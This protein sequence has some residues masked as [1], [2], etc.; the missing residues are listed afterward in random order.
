MGARKLPAILGGDHAA[1]I[2]YAPLCQGIPRIEI[3]LGFHVHNQANQLPGVRS[4]G[5][6]TD[7]VSDR[8]LVNGFVLRIQAADDAS[9]LVRQHRNAGHLGLALDVLLLDIAHRAVPVLRQ[10]GFHDPGQNCFFGEDSLAGRIVARA[11][12]CAM[13]ALGHCGF[14]VHGSSPSLLHSIT[15]LR[16]RPLFFRTPGLENKQMYWAAT[17]PPP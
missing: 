1:A 12:I 3:V 9:F 17:E 2:V 10:T 13:Q 6:E 11:V 15:G 16:S 5:A 7:I 4:N 8:S 14:L